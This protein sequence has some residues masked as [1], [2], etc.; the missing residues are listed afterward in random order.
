MKTI[1]GIAIG[2]NLMYL[3]AV[4]MVREDIS[5]WVHALFIA[6]VIMFFVGESRR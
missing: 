6:L 4:V 3:F 5:W 1:S 2:A